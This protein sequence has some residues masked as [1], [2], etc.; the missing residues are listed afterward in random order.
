MRVAI[1]ADI[2]LYRESLVEVLTERGVEVVATA[3]SEAPTDDLGDPRPELVLVDTAVADCTAT[4]RRLAQHLPQADVVAIG[5]PE[6]E[7]HVV[8]CAEAGVVGYVP[9]EGSLDD[10]VDTIRDVAR[11]ES[12]C[13]LTIA[14]SL[15][16]RVA[17]LAAQQRPDTDPLTVRELQIIELIHQGL[18]NKQIAGQLCIQLSTVKN[19]VHNILEKLQVRRRADAAARVMSAGARPYAW[20]SLH[21]RGW[22]S[23]VQDGRG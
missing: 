4:L 9:R 22:G 8:A 17:T 21:P 11:G 7:P 13:S 23:L 14:A 6:T 20:G 18:S 15:L 5:V 12:L 16:R 19:H 2:R 3:D 10:L 1:V